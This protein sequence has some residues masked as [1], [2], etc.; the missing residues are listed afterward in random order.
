M[1]IDTSG[2]ISP[3]LTWSWMA[4]I[5]ARR[6]CKYGRRMNRLSLKGTLTQPSSISHRANAFTTFCKNLDDFTTENDQNYMTSLFCASFCCISKTPLIH[7]LLPTCGTACHL[8][9][10]YL[11]LLETHSSLTL[12]HITLF[13]NAQTSIDA[14]SQVCLFKMLFKSAHSAGFS[15][16]IYEIFFSF[17]LPHSLIT[18]LILCPQPLGNHQGSEHHGHILHHQQLCS[19]DQSVPIYQILHHP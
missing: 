14:C 18:F 10:F 12:K 13:R 15:Q 17:F 11:S 8:E 5:A 19:H 2:S 3:F 4:E 7:C 16:V 6:H 1:S 9:V